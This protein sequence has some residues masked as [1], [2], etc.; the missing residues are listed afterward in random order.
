MAG[1]RRKHEEPL[2]RAA[3]AEEVAGAALS[4][5]LAAEEQ[6]RRSGRMSCVC[7]PAPMMVG[8]IHLQCSDSFSAW[9]VL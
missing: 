3:A 4:A 2:E 9:L 1:G 8:D 7:V 5:R 6:V